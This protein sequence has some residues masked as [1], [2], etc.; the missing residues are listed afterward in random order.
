V[1]PPD[2]VLVFVHR[3]IVER[4]DEPW[5]VARNPFRSTGGPMT[6]RLSVGAWMDSLIG[7][8]VPEDDI[9][10]VAVQRR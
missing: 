3:R 2:G 10:V 4:R 9:A 5:T 1:L 6:P 8:R 7:S